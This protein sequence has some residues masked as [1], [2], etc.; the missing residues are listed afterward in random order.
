MY[1]CDEVQ[2][3][4]A[5]MHSISK[6]CITLAWKLLFLFNSMWLMLRWKALTPRCM[7]CRAISIQVYH[8]LHG[9]CV[10]GNLCVAQKVV[11]RA[12]SRRPDFS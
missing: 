1:T 10:Y 2:V 9:S 8:D 12:L 4:K 3:Q 5:E 6:T 11:N 7:L